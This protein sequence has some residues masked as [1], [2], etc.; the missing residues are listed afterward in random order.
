MRLFQL[1][2]VCG[3]PND[4]N[5]WFTPYDKMFGVIVRAKDGAHA[6]EIAARECGDEGEQVWLDSRYTS[7]VDLM[8]DG[9][10]GVIITDFHAG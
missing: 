6:R 1:S 8:Q 7:C 4:D 10:E 3:L 5:P 9:V 2:R